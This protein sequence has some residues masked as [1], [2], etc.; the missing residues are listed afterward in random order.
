MCIQSVIVDNAFRGAATFFAVDAT[1]TSPLLVAV[2][3]PDKQILLVT[4]VWNDSLRLSHFGPRLAQALATSSLSVQWV[5]A[6]DG[7]SESEVGKLKKLIAA[8]SEIYADVSYAHCPHRYRKG[9][10]IYQA[11]DIN[12]TADWF[13]FVDA[14]G[15][16][17]APTIISL[18]EAAQSSNNV[19]VGVRLNTPENPVHR[20]LGRAASF[21]LFTLIVRCLLGV[22]LVD[23]QCGAKVVPAGTFR[24]I[25]ARLQEHGFVF[26]AE[27]LLALQESGCQ[28]TEVPIPWSEMPNGKVNPLRDAWRML[29]GLLRIRGR[30][31]SKLYKQ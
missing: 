2:P 17:D 7:S 1:V 15:A 20:P 24:L 12:H 10:A 14:D 21:K 23:T 5:I 22:S 13:A 31:K 3:S 26:D 9:G 28:I 6:D 30:L 4:P 18:L 8:L 25:R 19:V 27:L 29:L 16:I 11:W